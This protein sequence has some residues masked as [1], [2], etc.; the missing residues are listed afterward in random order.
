MSAPGR[1]LRSRMLSLAVLAAGAFAYPVAVLAGG[2]PHFPSQRDCIV[3][4]THDG[5]ILLV[6]GR[7]DS[8]AGA[9]T[10]LDRIRKLGY[11]HAEVMPDGGCELVKVAVRG[12]PT[13]AGAQNAVD[14]AAR[15]GLHPTL[16]QG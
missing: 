16:E 5:S 7:F 11:V 3:P 14:E 6:F 4:A 15:V 1:F 10:L 13:L 2:P 8:V 12:Y 9:E